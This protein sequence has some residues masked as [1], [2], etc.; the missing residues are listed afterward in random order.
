MRKFEY[1]VL[2]M[3]QYEHGMGSWSTALDYQG[4]QGWE[5]VSLCPMGY[6]NSI[7]AFFKRPIKQ[8]RK[9]VKKRGS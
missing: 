2:D 5:L 3:S 9:P 4:N 6:G 7:H 8:R 1:W